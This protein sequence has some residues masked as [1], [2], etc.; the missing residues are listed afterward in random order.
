MRYVPPRRWFRFRLRTWI[1]ALMAL[2]ISLGWW[3]N[4]ALRQKRAVER[5]RSLGISVYQ[6]SDDGP[7]GALSDWLET[8]VDVDYVCNATLVLQRQQ[9][10]RQERDEFLATL[11]EL[12]QLNMVLITGYPPVTDEDLRQLCVLR[13]LRVL[14]VVGPPITASGLVHLQKL[15]ALRSLG[16][17]ESR[18]TADA[19]QV[20]S[21]L[22]NLGGLTLHKAQ[23]ND[24]VLRHIGTMKKLRNLGLG[25][26][27]GITDDNLM[28]LAGMTE[29]HS[30]DISGAEITDS[31]LECLIGL[32]QLA[33]VVVNY[34]SDPARFQSF[35][36]ARPNCRLTSP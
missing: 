32:E 4:S 20:I 14:V 15:S 10:D 22:S 18:L 27:S 21:R 17:Y 2:S 19:A 1:V 5:L 28:H 13:R 29:L 34:G 26:S 11:A 9:L 12:P 25:E 35:R 30:L 6:I 24:D 31:G 23:L 16:L 8:W 3:S 33:W 36:A 7:L